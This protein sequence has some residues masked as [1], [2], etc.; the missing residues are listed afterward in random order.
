MAGERVDWANRDRQWN[1]LLA[2]SLTCLTSV[3]VLQ[4]ISQASV[5]H[6]ALQE[7]AAAGVTESIVSNIHVRYVSENHRFTS[8]ELDYPVDY[9]A[10]NILN[11]QVSS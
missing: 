9:S 5:K 6:S 4:S 2:I 7:P 11:S 1:E 10:L 8:W 3:I